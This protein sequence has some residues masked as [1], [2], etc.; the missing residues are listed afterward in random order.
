MVGHSLGA[1]V[2]GFIGKKIQ[3]L[4]LGKV[5]RITGENWSF[6]SQRTLLSYNTL[7]PVFF[8]YIGKKVLCLFIIF[9]QGK[10]C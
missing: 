8:I 6:F 10:L 7:T 9:G 2:V 5:P 3:E 1:H 4:G